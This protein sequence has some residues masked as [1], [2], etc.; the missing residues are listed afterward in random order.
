MA[1]SKT[2]R[3]TVFLLIIVVAAFGVYAAATYPRT[4]VGFQV[5]FTIGADVRRASF[6][7]PSMNNKVQV[8]S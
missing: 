6:E 3:A 4:A 7:V 2:L 5:S 8:V 1:L